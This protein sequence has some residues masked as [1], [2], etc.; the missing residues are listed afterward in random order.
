MREFPD[1]ATLLFSLDDT[2]IKG[3]KLYEQGNYYGALEIY[4]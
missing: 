4:E 1:T 2:K 3:N